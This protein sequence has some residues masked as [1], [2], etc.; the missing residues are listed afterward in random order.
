MA[1]SAMPTLP[2]HGA[3]GV[4]ILVSGE[5]RAGKTRVLQAV[6]T[7]ALDAGLSVGGFLSVARIVGGVKVGIDLLDVATGSIIPLATRRDERR[8][9]GGIIST[10][11]YTFDPTA[12]ERG[13]D[14]ARTGK[15]AD[16]FFVDELGPLEFRQGLGWAGVIPLIR[17][18]TFGVAFVVVRPELVGVAQE[19][20]ALAPDSPLITVDAVNRDELAARLS[21][22]VRKRAG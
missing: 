6:R 13:L 10:G 3:Q 7:A 17:A 19:Q 16:V 8:D 15:A 5:R 21:A 2:D 1:E 22:W 20:M 4:V 12:L 14:Y 11:H 9:T 18:R